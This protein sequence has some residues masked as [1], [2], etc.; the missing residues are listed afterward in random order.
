MFYKFYHTNKGTGES[1]A[2]A[3]FSNLGKLFSQAPP[4]DVES[5]DE[6]AEEYVEYIYK[7]RQY[8]MASLC[9]VGTTPD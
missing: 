6:E 3:L 5:S 9:N 8:F 4:S 2:A 1:P 7:P